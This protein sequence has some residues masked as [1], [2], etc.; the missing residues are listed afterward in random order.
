MR[1]ILLSLLATVLGF[2]QD[3]RVRAGQ[4]PPWPPEHGT[5]KFIADLGP[6][7]RALANKPHSNGYVTYQTSSLTAW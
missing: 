2:S 7:P 4:E 5:V 3:G 6:L 1:T